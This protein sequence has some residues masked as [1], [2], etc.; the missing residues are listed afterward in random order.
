MADGTTADPPATATENAGGTR[1]GRIAAAFEAARAEGRAALMPYLMGG[2]PDRATAS[3]VAE[4]YADSGADLIELGVPFS[5]PLADGPVIHAAATAA[6]EAG[7]TLESALETC[8]AVSARLPVVAM[9]YANMLLGDL[10]GN[11][12]QLAAAGACGAIVP[13]L[14]LEEAPPAREALNKEGL[15]L[16]PLVAPTTPDER[17][18]AICESAQGFVYVVST[19]GTTGERAELPPELSDLVAATKDEAE[20]PVAVGFG[21]STPEQAAAVG[22]LADG[23]IIGSRLVRAVADAHDAA[24]ATAAVSDLLRGSAEALSR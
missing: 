22:R 18:R 4:A 16:V 9:I 6:L 20:V 7:A 19:V 1:A 24:S 21:I 3:A 5:D 12:R 17:R 2:F 14:P 11:A 8:A 15:A 10:P 13:D 23:I